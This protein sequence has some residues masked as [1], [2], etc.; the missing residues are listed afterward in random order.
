MFFTNTNPQKQVYV[1][2]AITEN[3]FTFLIA[4]HKSA[5]DVIASK[6]SCAK[7]IQVF[8]GAGNAVAIV[9]KNL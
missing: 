3:H 2:C 9:Y 1:L 4:V 7:Q 6:K 5:K 8:Y